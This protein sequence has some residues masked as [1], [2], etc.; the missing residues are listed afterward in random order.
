MKKVFIVTGMSCAACAA[1]VETA[2]K[3]IDGVD[4]C[5]VNLLTASLL[6]SG[7][8]GEEKIKNA[9]IG[10]GYGISDKADNTSSTASPFKGRIIR[11]VLSLSVVILLMYISMGHMLGVP[12][13]FHR[14]P[15]LNA[16]VQAVLSLAVML[17]NAR[18]FINGVRGVFHMAPNMDT[19][20]SMGSLVSFGYSVYL[21]IKIALSDTSAG[22]EL[23]HGLYF[24]SAAMI[25][26]LISFGK[27]LE[28]VAKGK[29]TSA[30]QALIELTPDTANVLVDGKEVSVKASEVKIG[31][32][33]VVRPGER[34]PC[35]GIVIDGGTSV[36]ESILTGE[37]IP[38]EKAC[39]DKV[40]AGSINKSGFITC[41]AVVTSDGTV[42]AGVIKMVSDA[43][44]TKAPIARLADRV[45]G[46]FVPV[47]MLL[48][49]IT[50]ATWLLFLNSGIGYAVERAIAVLVISCPCALGLATPVAIMVGGGVG[51]KH[52][53]LYKNATAIETAGRVRTVVLDKTGTVTE[54]RMSVADI[55]AWD[56]AEEELLAIASG[57]EGYSEHPIAQAICTYALEK[58]VAPK[59]ITHF[60]ALAGRGVSGI[61]DEK[62]VLGVSLSYAKMLTTID[63][64]RVKLCEKL[65]SSGKTT[66]LILRDKLPI[67]V[68]A[69]ADT[70][71]SDAMVGIRALRNMG[72][73]TVLL[74]G[75]NK[76]VAA[77]VGQAIGV[78]EIVA[79]VL[80]EDK[81]KCV[82]TLMER[83]RVCMVGDG[84]NDAPA[85]VHA[86]LG[87]AIG[88][89]TDI[90]IDSADVVLT[91]SGVLDVAYA[92]SIGRA[93][94]RVI[95][96]NLFFAFLYNLLGIPLAM[97]V[98]GV[99]LPPMFG[100][101]A[102]SL[103]SFSVV[104]NAL[105]LNLW[106][107][108]YIKEN[109]A[110]KIKKKIYC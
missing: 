85:I 11:L 77:A 102:M 80:P 70:V 17:L 1:R 24:E 16:S 108:K 28:A 100:A 107:P 93:T 106:H 48:S 54:G 103:S 46:V 90:A 60:S 87:I 98:F 75:D 27:L 89:G 105:R 55:F 64:E 43:T 45:S 88:C 79:E 91:N 56:T 9:V 65:A 23:L 83:G 19:L 37:S 32:A 36:D 21:L 110:V 92:I 5:S 12:N 62:E 67:G 82:R 6:V 73:Y 8:A 58:G 31:D 86:D 42:L 33:F 71:K 44:A 97:G 72:I 29:T 2:V 66:V 84:I 14:Y 47:V 52:G 81:Q 13:P 22:T 101:L 34:I 4:E 50:L 104:M 10:A 59:Q 7:S 68:F 109:K 38:K 40:L 35:D 26:A 39:G 20:V 99:S 76:S 78:D 53:V 25:L 51:A 95:K 94:L 15:L 69:V 3:A 41:R 63:I 30:I 49:I 96:G 61:D 74:T 57:L 18:F